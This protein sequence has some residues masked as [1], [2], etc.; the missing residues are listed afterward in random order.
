MASF[1]G[2]N[3]ITV[4]TEEKQVNLEFATPCIIIHLKQINQSDATTSQVYYFMFI[5][6]YS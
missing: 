3:D 4:T 5:H 2:T 6:M 1:L